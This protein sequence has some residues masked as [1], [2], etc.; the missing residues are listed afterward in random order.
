MMGWY[1]GMGGASGL[2]W[3]GIG[4]VVL[5][6]IAGGVAHMRI[7]GRGPRGL[8]QSDGPDARRLLDETF[9]RGGLTEEEYLRRRELLKGR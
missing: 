5:L 7:P 2:G 4:L 1:G 3:L 9:A 8:Q 6:L